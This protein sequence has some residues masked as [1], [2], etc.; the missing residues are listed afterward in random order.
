[1]NDQEGNIQKIK[2][3]LDI[4]Q[5]IN[6]FSKQLRELRKL[7]KE[8]NVDILEIMKVNDIDCFDCNSG[9]IIYTK[10]NVKKA[11][12]KKSLLSILQSYDNENNTETANQL[13]NYILENRETQI[14]ENIKLKI[15]K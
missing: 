10:S 15:N 7:K 14:R 4:E 1:M 11:I 2:Q 5:K 8:L 3:W 9:Q 12:N 13:C 6:H